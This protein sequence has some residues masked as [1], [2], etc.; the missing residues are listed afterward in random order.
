MSSFQDK[1]Q[2]Q[3]SQI[4]KEVMLFPNLAEPLITTE[5]TQ[6]DSEAYG[7]FHVSTTVRLLVTH[8]LTS[9]LHVALQIPRPQQPWETNLRPKS[10]R[11]S[12][13]GSHL[14]LLHLLQHRWSTPDQHRWFHHPRLLLSRCPVFR[15]QGWWYAMVDIL[16]CLCFL[17]CYWEYCQRCLLV[18]ILLHFQVCVLVVVELASHQV[19]ITR[20]KVCI[21]E[22]CLLSK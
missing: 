18:P 12:R 13:P 16:G 7:G 11:L 14:F 15:Q 22:Q 10:L 2:A 20:K 17:D 3:I 8:M 5:S 4:D 6:R 19:S 9:L 21:C 1:A